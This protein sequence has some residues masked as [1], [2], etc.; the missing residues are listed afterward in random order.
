MDTGRP[1]F[2][3]VNTSYSNDGC[4]HAPQNTWPLAVAATMI[5]G[6]SGAT[7]IRRNESPATGV[8]IWFHGG[9]D[10]IPLQVTSKGGATPVDSIPR[11]TLP[12]NSEYA[13]QSSRLPRCVIW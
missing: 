1:P 12:G 7:W 11:N 9:P 2:G 3:S 8:L 13:R 5:S 4:C 6:L 10:H